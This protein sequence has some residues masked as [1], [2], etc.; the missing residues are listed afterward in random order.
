M[1][2]AGIEGNECVRT[3]GGGNPTALASLQIKTKIM[4]SEVIPSIDAQSQLL[5]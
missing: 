5:G 2:Q 3:G 1:I 4:E